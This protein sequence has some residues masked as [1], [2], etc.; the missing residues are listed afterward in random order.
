MKN[1]KYILSD[2]S[3]Q[4]VIFDGECNLCNRWVQFVIK[5]DKK[6]AFK[7]CSLQSYLGKQLQD[8]FIRSNVP[9]DSVIYVKGNKVYIRSSAAL[10]ILKDI[11]LPY[12]LL[13]I[14]ISVPAFLRNWIYDWVAK[15]RYVLFGKKQQCMIP[16]ED[17][18]DRFI[19]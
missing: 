3:L 17:T 6:K 9:V 10:R 13:F 1:N 12:S 5:K 16:S 11:K 2:P 7:F 8:N 19:N 18:Q 15:N 4:L 14:F